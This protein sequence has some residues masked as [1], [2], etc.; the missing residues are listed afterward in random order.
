VIPLLSEDVYTIGTL[1]SGNG[2]HYDHLNRL[3]RFWHAVAIHDESVVKDVLGMR[4]ELLPR[5]TAPAYDEDARGSEGPEIHPAT[6]AT[7]RD[8]V[9]T[10]ERVHSDARLGRYQRPGGELEPPPPAVG[11][12]EIFP[13][14][15][16]HRVEGVGRFVSQHDYDQFLEHRSPSVDRDDASQTGTSS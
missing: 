13:L 12:V 7:V 3:G 16:S 4:P 14:E 9:R 10:F 5:M 8:Y 15:L 6:R 11:N 2:L 1:H